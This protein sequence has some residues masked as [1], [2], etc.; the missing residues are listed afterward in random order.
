VAGARSSWVL[1]TVGVS[2]TAGVA[3]PLGEAAE[4]AA[5]GLDRVA[6]TPDDGW[7]AGGWLAVPALWLGVAC[8]VDVGVLATTGA[9]LVCGSTRELTT[10]PTAPVTG[11]AT[12]WTTPVTPDV[13]PESKDG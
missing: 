5:A 8:F 12:A 11:S 13:S 7:P 1:D 3:A 6:V 4:L 9:A 2:D 10:D